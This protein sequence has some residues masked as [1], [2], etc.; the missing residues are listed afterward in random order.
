MALDLFKNFAKVQV[1]TGY[2]ASATSI[3]LTAGHGTKLPAPPFNATYWN[4]T[5]FPDPSDD[6]NVEIV[7]VT[8]VAS[9]TLT[10]TRGQEGIAAS[11]KNTASKTYRMI[12]GLTA[13]TFNTDLSAGLAQVGNG[14]LTLA[15][16]EPVVVA[17]DVTGAT[18][19]Y[20]TPYK[21]NVI[22]L[23]DGTSWAAYTFSELSLPLGTLVAATNYDVF[24]Y[25]NAG[26]PTLE[27]GAAWT[28]G[29]TRAVALAFQNG[30]YVKSGAPTRRYLGTFRTT[31]TTTTEDSIT[32]RLL[33]N[34]DNQIIRR[35]Y[36]DDAAGHSYTGGW[37]IYNADA[38]NKVEVVVGLLATANMSMTVQITGP[39]AGAAYAALGIGSTA[40]P[41]GSLFFSNGGAAAIGGMFGMPWPLVQGYSEI[42]LIENCAAGSATFAGGAVSIAFFN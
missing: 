18:A 11:T 2:D 35:A 10:V 17:T 40:G 3:A 38:T 6:P 26:T 31:S 42:N 33:W 12:A 30:I 21:G 22:S 16:G 28:N 5:D 32:K 39:G 37:R 9:D 25:S 20:F 36:K 8:A 29:T 19:I 34:V 24:I 41:T 14:R 15:S 13:K 4:D 27:I 7:R 23:Y 1:S